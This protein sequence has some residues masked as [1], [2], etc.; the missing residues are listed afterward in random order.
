MV[1]LERP[2]PEGIRL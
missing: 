1:Q 2:N